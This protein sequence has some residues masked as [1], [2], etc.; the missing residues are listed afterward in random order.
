MTS[1]A[2]TEHGYFGNDQDDLSPQ[3]LAAIKHL[4]DYQ[5]GMRYL[6]GKGV[7]QDYQTASEHFEKAAN[8]G[9]PYAQNELAYLYAFGKGVPQ[10]YAA[11]LSWYQKA[12]NQGLASAQYNLG[13]MYDKGIGTPVNKMEARKWFQQAANRGF[14][15]ARQALVGR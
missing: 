8:R 9:N 6:L 14:D 2:S 5:L 13:L 3:Q 15:P 7:K 10:D 12:A 1:C 11:A 4:D